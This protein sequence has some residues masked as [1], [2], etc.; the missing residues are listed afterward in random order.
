M[1]TNNDNQLKAEF[2]QFSSNYGQI[3]KSSTGL[4]K[5]DD[6]FFASIKL[7][8]LKKWVLN[9]G[10]SYEILDFGCGIGTLSRLLAKSFLNSQ[11][12]GYDISEECLS[13]SKKNNTN[14]KNVQFVNDL[15][16]AG[17][18]DLIIAANVF[19]HIGPL[20]RSNTLSFLKKLLNPKGRIIIFEHNP[21]NPLTR[22]IVRSCPFDRDATLIQ[23]HEFY[24][25]AKTS[26]FK[27]INN[28]YILFFPW[29]GRVFRQIEVLLKNIPLGAQY[30]LSLSTN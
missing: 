13:V 20:E 2:D 22:S 12:Y 14:L 1:K 15:S 24:K 21:F 4:L 3:L 16:Q 8:C 17:K 7:Y 25:L 27:V 19:H 6:D 11:V 28:F 5:K 18:Y 10:N 29:S 26:N 23:R 30:M 9:D